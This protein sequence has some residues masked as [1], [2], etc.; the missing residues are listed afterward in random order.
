[1]SAGAV[2]FLVGLFMAFMGHF[3]LFVGT[4]NRDSPDSFDRT[5][6]WLSRRVLRPG[7][8]IVAAVGAVVIVA[9]AVIG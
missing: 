2:A 6:D 1:M 9:S 8:L 7:G 3:L 4:M 5:S